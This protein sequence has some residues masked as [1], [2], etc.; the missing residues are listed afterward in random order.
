MHAERSRL[1]EAFVADCTLE[2]L[3]GCVYVSKADFDESLKK[4]SID[5]FVFI[6]SRKELSSMISVLSPS[7]SKNGPIARGDDKF[8]C[9][10]CSSDSLATGLIL[11]HLLL[12]LL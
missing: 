10:D 12:L 4:K 3:L 9:G 6:P 8:P 2:R 5:Q 7:A 1:T 11:M